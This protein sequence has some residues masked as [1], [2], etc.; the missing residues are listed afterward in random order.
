[1]SL[2][3]SVISSR[4]TLHASLS[5]LYSHYFQTISAGSRVNGPSIVF[6]W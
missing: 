5:T 6:Q 1:M 4:S 2:T 3:Q